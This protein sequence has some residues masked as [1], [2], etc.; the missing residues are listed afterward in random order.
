MT[1]TSLALWAFSS[2]SIAAPID[3]EQSNLKWIGQKPTSEHWGHLQFESGDI[4]IHKGKWVGGE[5]IVDMNSMTVDDISGPRADKLLRHLKNEDFFGVDQ[6][7]TAK[8]R[9]KSTNATE[10]Q[11]NLTIK[12][13]THPISFSYTK[14]DKAYIGKM[15]FNRT[16]YGILTNPNRSSKGLVISSL[17]M[18]LSSNLRLSLK[19][20]ID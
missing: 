10:I 1:I 20:K 9:I 2:L 3:T 19:T 17:K 4:A 18:M 7:E 14:K 12:G 11:A 15:I 6:H 13:Q 5:F 8:L 16:L